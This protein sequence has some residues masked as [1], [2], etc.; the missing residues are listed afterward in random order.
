MSMSTK[1][2]E[3]SVSYVSEVAESIVQNRENE[4]ES[5]L[6]LRIPL[7]EIFKD[8]ILKRCTIQ[9]IWKLKSKMEQNKA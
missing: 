5:G 8:N 1:W 6:N 3:V 2:G 7:V 9:K 4:Q